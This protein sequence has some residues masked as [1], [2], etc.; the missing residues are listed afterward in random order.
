MDY[1]SVDKAY[2][3]PRSDVYL[4][5]WSERVAE[6]KRR[7]EQAKNFEQAYLKK[8][9]SH[10]DWDD[11]TPMGQLQF[12]KVNMLEVKCVHQVLKLYIYI[13]NGDLR[14][15]IK[16]F[17]K[18]KELSCDF[19]AEIEERVQ[20]GIDTEGVYLKVCKRIKE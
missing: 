17:E 6:G 12:T 19:L 9:Q 8:L 20:R 3:W 16:S 4:E 5:H 15:C 10:E 7:I 11:L 13:Y 14:N 1:K 2:R 18:L